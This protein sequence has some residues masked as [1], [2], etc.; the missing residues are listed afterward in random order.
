MFTVTPVVHGE[1]DPDSGSA[2]LAESW[3]PNP[4]P[5]ESIICNKLYRTSHLNRRY[6]TE[7]GMIS[8]DFA[9]VYAAMIDIVFSEE[10]TRTGIE[11]CCLV[12][13]ALHRGEHQN[14]N[15]SL[16]RMDFAN[17]FEPSSGPGDVLHAQTEQHRDFNAPAHLSHT[18]KDRQDTNAPHADRICWRAGQ[19]TFGYR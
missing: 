17:Q 15:S 7:R 1:S 5:N 3:D 10:I 11:R 2:E 16:K 18:G 19:S 12:Q 6:H 9:I 4:R 13:F 8:R 14:R